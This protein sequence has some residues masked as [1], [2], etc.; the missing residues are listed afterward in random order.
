[1]TLFGASD[2][3]ADAPFWSSIA[4]SDDFA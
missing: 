3:G 2:Q 4:S 1:L